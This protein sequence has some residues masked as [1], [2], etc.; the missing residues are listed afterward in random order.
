VG[1]NP[2][3]G[4]V[5]SSSSSPVCTLCLRGLHERKQVEVELA[6]VTLVSS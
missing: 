2:G 1:S 3:H 4:S 5:S 6:Q